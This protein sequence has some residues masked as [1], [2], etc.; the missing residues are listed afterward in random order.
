MLQCF[1]AG[2]VGRCT[3]NIGAELSNSRRL[4]G[5]IASGSGG[6]KKICSIVDLPATLYIYI[7]Y[8]RAISVILALLPSSRVQHSVV[9]NIYVRVCT[10]YTGRTYIRRQ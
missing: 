1:G 4:V 10:Q 2:T 5:G 9:Y 3:L 8:V 6:E 7:Y